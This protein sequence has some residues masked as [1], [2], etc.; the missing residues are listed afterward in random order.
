MKETDLYHPIKSYLEQLGYEVKAEVM[1]CDVVAVKKDSEHP[2]IIECKTQFNL[3]V[4][5]QAIERLQMSPSVYI[6]VPA[7]CSALK[8]RTKKNALIKL[9]RMLGLGLMTVELLETK[10]GIIEVLCEPS[11]YTYPRQHRKSAKLMQEFYER[12]GD[13]NEGGSSQKKL[14]TAYRQKA[15]LLAAAMD[16]QQAK[17]PAE[18]R[19]QTGIPNSGS[20]LQ[21]NVY[22]WFQK[23]EKGQY[24]LSPEG[25]AALKQYDF[26]LQT[27][28][29][30]SKSQ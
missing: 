10:Q 24:V 26:I 30:R 5:L 2:L 18:L 27:L 29:S 20:I 1:Q 19:K 17:S 16:E 6:A 8:S 13:F 9:N 14:V 25:K 7:D 11:P 28:Q 3:T 15:L 22:H 12:L 23:K 21:R 4:V